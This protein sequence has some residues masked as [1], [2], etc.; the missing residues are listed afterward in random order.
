MPFA[1]G[2]ALASLLAGLGGSA[3]SAFGKK[4]PAETAQLPTRDPQQMDWMSQLGQQGMANVDPE[5]LEKH[6][7]KMF[8]QEI[9]PSIAQRY[10]GM[11]ALDSTGFDK[12][13]MGASQNLL[14]G[15]QGQRS[16]L[17]L[18]QLMMALQPQFENMYQPAGP[19]AMQSFGGNIASAGLQ[20]LGPSLGLMG[21]QMGQRNKAREADKWRDFFKQSQQK[22]VASREGELEDE[23]EQTTQ[24]YEDQISSLRNLLGKQQS[25]GVNWGLRNIGRMF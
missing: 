20:S 22:G 18:Q 25:Q 15:L 4:S 8:Q 13:M 5:A 17:G 16:G 11:G 6:S 21:Q 3:M 10:A 9:M 12:S 14:E 7:M 19:G 2:M 24:G 1:E 23:I